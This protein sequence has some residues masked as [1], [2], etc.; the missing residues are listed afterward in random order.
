MRV[1]VD[2]EIVRENVKR[3]EAI[4]KSINAS[5]SIM[6]KDFYSELEIQKEVTNRIWSSKN[7]RNSYNYILFQNNIWRH[8]GGLVI[9]KKEVVDLS[10]RCKRYRRKFQGFVPVNMWDDREGL[11]IDDAISLMHFAKQYENKFFSLSSALITN[12]CLNDDLHSV[13]K[14]RLK[15]IKLKVNGAKY[16]SIGGSYYLGKIFDNEIKRGYIDEVR[17]GEYAMFGTIPFYDKMLGKN[18][19]VL[20]LKVIKLYED[21]KHALLKGGSSHVDTNLSEL[22]NDNVKFVSNSTEYTIVKYVNKPFLG[23]KI[24]FIPNYHSLIKLLN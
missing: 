19:I 15:I 13:Q 5:C 23:S 22:I 10:K 16:I 12:G 24:Q 14:L 21:R 6:V 4:C 18:A 7:I 8:K 2:L 20:E 3:A 11:H 17:I 1:K 9:T